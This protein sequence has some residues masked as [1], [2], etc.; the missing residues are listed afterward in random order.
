MK[1]RPWKRYKFYCGTV[2]VRQTG[3]VAY[4]C[5]SQKKI[6]LS[7]NGLR[8]IEVSSL[9]L[10]CNLLYIWDYSIAVFN[11][12]EV[13]VWGSS[14]VAATWHYSIIVNS[15]HG[16][17]RLRNIVAFSSNRKRRVDPGVKNTRVRLVY[18]LMIVSNSF[19]FV[20]LV[21][22]ALH[23]EV[24]STNSGIFAG[25]LLVFRACRLE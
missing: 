7:I 14:N 22:L 8:S 20:N 18:V 24:F 4:N 21:Y 12:V 10:I 13:F 9:I 6:L 16:D 25:S 17:L 5:G 2:H 15:T 19:W 23:V 1:T 3:V 11:P